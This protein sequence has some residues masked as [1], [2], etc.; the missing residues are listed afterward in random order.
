MSTLI[1]IR[2][3]YPH[4][5]TDEPHDYTPLIQS[6]GA[7]LVRYTP[8]AYSGDS[9]IL[10]AQF[11]KTPDD[12]TPRFGHLTLSW[13]SCSGCDALQGC[14]SYESLERLREELRLKIQWFDTREEILAY[15][16]NHDWKGDHVDDDD[17]QRFLGAAIPLLGGTV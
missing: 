1:D 9:F 2:A 6:L 13:G 3:L 17:V 7:V 15:Y 12:G 10:Y 5:D 16:K 14:G 11:R 8:W 4:P